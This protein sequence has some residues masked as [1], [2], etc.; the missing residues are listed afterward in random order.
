MIKTAAQVVIVYEDNGTRD[1]ALKFFDQLV[2]RFWSRC[3]FDL[4][5]VS[6][7]DLDSEASL[8]TAIDKAAKS[9]LIIFSVLPNHEI[10][11]SVRAWVEAWVTR[12]AEREGVI[13][14]L[15][16]PG[17]SMVG[18]ASSNYRY[19]RGIA[20]RAGMDYLTQLP[21]TIN[22]AIP[23]SLDSVSKRACQVTSVLDQILQKKTPPAVFG[24]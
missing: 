24:S 10:P 20:L 4:A 21:E 13:V 9:A 14:G 3:E 18:G 5:W 19:L 23:D 1:E 15:K 11:F 17:N 7:S 2:K 12:R 16:D 6:F 22:H 8:Q